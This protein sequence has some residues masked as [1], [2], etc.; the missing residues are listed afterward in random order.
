[1]KTDYKQIRM[2]EEINLLIEKGNATLDELG[3]TEH[4]KKHAAK[5][6]ETAGKILKELGYGKHKIELAKIAGY[7]HDIGNAVNRNDHAHSGAILAYQ[8]LKDT[9]LP[10]K[11]I[12][13]VT[14]AIGHHDE[15]TGTAVDP[16]SAALILADKT[17]VRRNRVQNRNKATFD[18]H[19]R[20]NYAALSSKL[21]IEKEKRMIQMELELDD[22]ICTVMDYFEIFLKRM[23]M[24]R[25]AAERLNCKFKLVANGSKLC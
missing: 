14:T 9:D 13:V 2:N 12:L 25:R 10:L 19:D 24:C 22:S 3:Y 1:M 4:S 20:V 16:V 21:I 15:A 18:I 8:I 23:I 17:D 11:D 6:S 5:V 7:M